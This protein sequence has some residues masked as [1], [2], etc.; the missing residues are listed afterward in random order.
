MKPTNREMV[1]MEAV[2]AG[3]IEVRSDGSVWRVAQRR[4][5]RWDAKTTVKP[6]LPR[7]IDAVAGAGYRTV[8][9]MVDGKQTSALAHRLVWVVMHGPIPPG[10]TINH[11]NGLKHDNRP[12]NLELA[13]YSEQ[14]RH[15]VHVL[16]TARAANQNGEA[17]HAA[18]LRAKAV[19]E[20][21]RRRAA[22]ERLRVIAADFGLSDRTVSKIA[23]RERWGFLG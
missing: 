8:K 19:R 11:K 17:N 13:T 2:R 7:R 4:K 22:G 6:V 12:E 1:L 20:I 16:G 9:C 5:S 10:L 15:A 14:I 18:K 3:W 21:R 23:R